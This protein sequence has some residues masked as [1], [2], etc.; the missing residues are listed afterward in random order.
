VLFAVPDRQEEF[1]MAIEGD[2][3]SQPAAPPRV[4]TH[5]TAVSAARIEPAEFPALLGGMTVFNDD[6]LVR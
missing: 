1:P 2:D 4:A 6:G 3:T 5:V